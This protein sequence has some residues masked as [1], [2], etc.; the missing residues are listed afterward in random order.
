[1]VR[2][3][4]ASVSA[5]CDYIPSYSS[6]SAIYSLRYTFEDVNFEEMMS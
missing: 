5:L 3:A 4:K 2:M 6:S 1:V